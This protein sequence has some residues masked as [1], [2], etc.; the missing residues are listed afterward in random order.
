MGNCYK[1][2][3]CMYAQ[4]NVYMHILIYNIVNCTNVNTIY[5]DKIFNISNETEGEV[6]QFSSELDWI[7]RIIFLS[8]FQKSVLSQWNFFLA[9]VLLEKGYFHGQRVSLQG[10]AFFHFQGKILRWE[11]TIFS[12]FT[13]AEN[14]YINIHLLVFLICAPGIPDCICYCESS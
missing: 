5:K 2:C 4:M 9:E 11:L 8:H 7:W 1:R 13:L 3:V 10:V 6:W 12:F 14:E